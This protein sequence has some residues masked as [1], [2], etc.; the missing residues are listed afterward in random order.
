MAD[1]LKEVKKM[2]KGLIGKLMDD[3]FKKAMKM[4][5]LDGV[6]SSSLPYGLAFYESCWRFRWRAFSV[7]VFSVH[8]FIVTKAPF[9]KKGAFT[10]SCAR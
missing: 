3:P 1:L 4:F 2:A 5:E 9:V 7:P 8:A 10:M 6:S